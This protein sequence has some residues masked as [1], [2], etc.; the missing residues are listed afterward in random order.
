[1]WNLN[2]TFRL[3]LLLHSLCNY[4]ADYWWDVLTHVLFNQS[5]EEEILVRDILYDALILVDYSFVNPGV[6]VEQADESTI[7]ILITRL[8][9][10]YEATEIAR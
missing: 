3:F 1:M 6:E 2:V 5:T 8:I 10:A 4:E 7:S 9:V